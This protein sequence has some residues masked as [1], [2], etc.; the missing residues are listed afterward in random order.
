[1]R[2]RL[3]ILLFSLGALQSASAALS[4]NTREVVVPSDLGQREVFA[5]FEFTNTGTETVVIT[6]IRHSCGCTTSALPTY[7]YEPGESGRL[8]VKLDLRGISGDQAK[9]ISVHTADE[10]DSPDR[11]YVYTSVPVRHAVEPMILAWQLRAQPS[12]RSA[13]V[14]FHPDLDFDPA[15][16][17]ISIEDRDATGVL[18]TADLIPAETPNALRIRV[19]PQRLNRTG[20]AYLSVWWDHAEEPERIGE[21]YL[22]VHP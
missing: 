3:A 6:D 14:T 2:T 13:S 4:W 10:P 17:R 16:I 11:L 8:E 1:M 9:V 20:H 7:I 12:S 5:V 18:F 19:L 22:V 15:Q 21:I